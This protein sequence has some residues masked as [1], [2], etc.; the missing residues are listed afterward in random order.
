[1]RGPAVAAA[2]RGGAL[3]TVSNRALITRV[4]S[5]AP[6]RPGAASHVTD[7]YLL[8]IVQMIRAKL[9]SLLITYRFFICTYRQY[10]DDIDKMFGRSSIM[11]NKLDLL[12]IISKIN[13]IQ[14]T[15]LSV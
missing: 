13:Y 12:F 2:A 8:E 11:T 9:F 7:R 3:A 6:L 10:L 15:T 1:M 5:C 4:I 14:R